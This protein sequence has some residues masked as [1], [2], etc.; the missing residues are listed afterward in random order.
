MKKYLEFEKQMICRKGDKVT[1]VIEGGYSDLAS[2]LKQ[3]CFVSSPNETI[4]ERILILSIDKNETAWVRK[5]IE[6]VV[7]FSRT[8][9]FLSV[10]L[11]VVQFLEEK[12]LVKVHV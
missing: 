8:V 11:H 7:S 5:E 2:I 4:S 1:F 12:C 9:C 10:I 3:S 6:N